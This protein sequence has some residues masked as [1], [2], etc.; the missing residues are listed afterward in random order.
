[1]RGHRWYA[2]PAL[3]AL[4]V[5]ALIAAGC[6]DDDETTTSPEAT[7]TTTTSAGNAADKIDAAVKSCGTK[8]QELPEAASAAL[9]A[10]CTTVGDNAK[11]ALAQGGEQADQALSQ[12]ADS[13]KSEVAKLP[14]GDAQ[15]ALTDLYDAISSTIGAKAES[16]TPP[17]PGRNP[18]G[19]QTRISL[20]RDL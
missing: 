8:A 18:D 19:R 9:Q 11:Q 20:R 16:T 4:F 13:C 2:V 3:T 12:A 15:A 5:C 6:G 14:A 7:T 17:P 10:A 1:M